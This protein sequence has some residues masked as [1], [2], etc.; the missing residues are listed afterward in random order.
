MAITR[1]Q[2]GMVEGTAIVGSKAGADSGGTSGQVVQLNASNEIA[3]GYLDT[4]TTDGKVVLAG[5]SDKIA[6]S[7]I[8][9]GTTDGKIVQMQSG[10][11]LPAVDGSL[12]TSIIE[13]FPVGMPLQ[14]QSAQTG[15]KFGDP[16]DTEW[17]SGGGDGT[18]DKFYQSN[19]SNLI[20][21]L[22]PKLAAS[23]FRIDVTWSGDLNNG[24]AEK[25]DETLNRDLGFYLEQIV[26][27]GDANT[28]SKLT[29]VVEGI[30]HPVISPIS[31]SQYDSSNDTN[32]VHLLNCSFSYIA[33]PSYELGEVI[34]YQLGA[35]IID[36][37]N[38]T[39]YTNRPVSSTVDNAHMRSVSS[40]IVTE[41]RGA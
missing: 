23:K 31:I 13:A 30:R 38:T 2:P 6:T 9:T 18:T 19:V 14:M 26:D 5:G 7:L 17:V 11:K 29:G 35:S 20:V 27:V 12:L 40:I 10:P 41:I 36:E 24:T 32:A 33:T 21:T 37:D 1:V 16:L 22:T 25:S 3:T 28:P 15:L 4:G 8:D 34:S 39:L